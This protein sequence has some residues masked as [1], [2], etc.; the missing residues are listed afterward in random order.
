LQS[1]VH[2]QEAA[3]IELEATQTERERLV[4]EREQQATALHNQLK[5]LEAETNQRREAV[6]QLEQKDEALQGEIRQRENTLAE[7]EAAQAEHKSA[8]AEQEQRTGELQDQLKRLVAKV[9]QHRE[10]VAQLEQSAGVLQHEVEQRETAIAELETVKTEQERR[11]AERER[12][13]AEL[14]ADVR[15]YQE[16]LPQLQREAEALQ[17]SVAQPETTIPDPKTVEVEQRPLAKTPDAPAHLPLEILVLSVRAYNALKRWGIDTVGQLSRMS[18]V[19]LLGVMNV[20][21]KSAAEIRAKLKD[22]LSHHPLPEESL[23]SSPAPLEP[24]MPSAHEPAVP[25]EPEPSPPLVDQALLAR[26]AL[27]SLDDIAVE[28]LVLSG[29]WRDQLRDRGITSI[30]ELTRQSSDVFGPDSPVVTQLRRYLNWLV[31]QD[32]ATWA[33]EATGRVISPAYR[34]LLAE[35]T[36]DELM[37]HWLGVLDERDRQVLKWRYGLDDERLTLDEIGRRL[38]VSRERVRQLQLRAHRRLSAPR[39]QSQIWLLVELLRHTFIEAGGLMTEF[40]M[41][42]LIAEFVCAEA[43]DAEWSGRLILHVFD[44]FEEV[45]KDRL[46]GFASA[47]LHLVDRINQGAVEL[48]EEEGAPLPAAHVLNALNLRAIDLDHERQDDLDDGFIAACLRT[49]RDVESADDHYALAAWTQEQADDRG[50]ELRDGDEPTYRVG[51]GDEQ[52]T[53]ESRGQG[54]LSEQGMQK[55]EDVLAE[56]QWRVDF[57]GPPVTLADWETYLR[58]WVRRVELLGEIPISSDERIQL[59]AA[60]GRLVRSERRSRAL[61]ALHHSYRAAFG[62]FLVAQ[63]VYGYDGRGGYWPG[64]GDVIDK[65]LNPSWIGELGRLFEKIIED[66]DLPFFPDLG[67]RRFVDLILAHSGIP[68]Y[69]LPDFFENMLQRSVTQIYFADMSAA[70][71]IEEWLWRGSG[72]Y[73]TD[74]PVLRFLEFG[75]EVAEDFVA[76]CRE[77]AWEYLEAGIVPEAE[78]VGLPERVVGA[79]GAWIVEQG[80]E[81]MEREAADRWR[82]RKPRILVDPWGEGVLLDLPPQ[83]VP[84]TEVY[85]DVAWQMMADE[86]AY[87]PLH[88]RV[89]RTSFDLKTESESFP[90]DRPAR[91]YKVSLQ[92]DEEVK[93]T[94]RFPGVSDERPLLVFD[95]ER[96][97]LLSW[98]HSLPARRLGLLYPARLDLDI[99]GEPDLVE[100]LPRFPWGWADSRGQTWDLSQATEIQRRLVSARRSTSVLRLGCAY[101]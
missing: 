78:D 39:P 4:A 8:I 73:I 19:Q 69:C 90:L 75:G 98:Q 26:A 56:P 81:A 64:V 91:V 87:P 83:Q 11:I 13:A 86:K 7:L 80:A 61:H 77:M 31:G 58:P 16:F 92:V 93:H 94:W 20:G 101:P 53:D 57:S 55:P 12:R 74:K 60:I 33:D 45:V 63:G 3:L 38:G 62:V 17:D 36:L 34:L 43:Y 52:Q 84:A 99:E 35:T 48:L 18:S 32:E 66:F 68:D 41:M 40:E 23:E 2:Q 37:E 65:P 1:E 97:T 89:R 95:P 15:Q 24:S 29:R 88:V 25:D 30:G 71:L 10:T 14:Q 28:R 46:W 9:E 5:S 42:G 82:L 51:E 96:F 47:S 76:R 6:A 49:N 54:E 22:Y 50:L 59:G 72:R 70:E 21:Q 79:Y 100:D 27:A 44:E 67:G 85:A